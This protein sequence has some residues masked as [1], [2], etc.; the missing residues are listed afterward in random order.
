MNDWLTTEQGMRKNKKTTLTLYPNG[1]GIG[2]VLCENPEIMIG[3]GILKV[4]PLT[5][6]K[7]L[8]VLF[9]FFE[10]VRPE[11]I[12][13][14]KRELDKKKMS[15]RVQQVVKE[16]CKES[17]ARSIQVHHYSRENIKENFQSYTRPVRH[18]I[19][20]V[21]S[22]WYPELKEKQPKER[23]N[24]DSEPY[25]AGLFDAF[26]LMLTHFKDH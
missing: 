13:I 10:Y 18:N 24:S 3:Y 4:L 15:F 23:K 26:S 6:E 7:Y 20:T 2:Y 11:T 14:R 21:I 25:Q 22:E 19:N 8:E 17:E 12:V 5:A 16:I 1:I 9:P